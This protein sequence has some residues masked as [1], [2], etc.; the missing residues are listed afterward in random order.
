MFIHHGHYMCSIGRDGVKDMIKRKF[1]NET[2]LE[3]RKRYA[4][5]Y[6]MKKLSLIYGCGEST[7][8]NIIHHKT[9]RDAGGPIATDA[10]WRRGVGKYEF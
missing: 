6:T 10:R 9:Y 8:N 1:S 7:I 5:G 3:I 4:E 2:V